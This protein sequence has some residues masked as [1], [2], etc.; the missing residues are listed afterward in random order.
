MRLGAGRNSEV[1]S[2][3]GAG[4]RDHTERIGWRRAHQR[5]HPRGGD[6]TSRLAID[7]PVAPVGVDAARCTRDVSRSPD[8]ARSGERRPRGVARDDVLDAMAAASSTRPTD[9]QAASALTYVYIPVTITY[10]DCD[11]H[12][13]AAPPVRAGRSSQ[14]RRANHH[15]QERRGG[16]AA[17][18]G[19][20]P[21]LARSHDDAPPR[22]GGGRRG[23]SALDDW[24]P[25]A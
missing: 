10:S 1:R 3:R 16:G 5:P 4:S 19:G 21:R 14:S 17:P 13:A 12:A 11:D 6:G 2:P 9:A 18:A 8:R 23:V 25:H 7:R 15:R 22:A 20:A 24:D